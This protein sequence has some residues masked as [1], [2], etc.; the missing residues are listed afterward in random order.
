M[1][2]IGRFSHDDEIHQLNKNSRIFYNYATNSEFTQNQTAK[3]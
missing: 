1:V 2:Q 3:I